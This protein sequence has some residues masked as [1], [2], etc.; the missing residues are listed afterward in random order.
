M[1]TKNNNFG[2]LGYGYV[3]RATHVGLLNNQPINVHDI[4]LGTTLANLKDSEYVFVCIPT[5]TY[6]DIINLKNEVQHLVIQ[7]PNVKIIIRS[8]LPIGTC[9]AI[10]KELGIDLIYIPEFLRERFWEEDCLKRPLV[11]GHTNS[12]LPEW[13]KNEKIYKCS[14]K[15]AEI[16]KI[17]SNTFAIMRIAFANLFYDLSQEMEADYETV[18]K[19]Y[20][21]IKHDQT[22]LEI[23]G[24]DGTRGFNGKCLP[25]DLDFFIDT[26]DANNIDS[27]WLKNIREN[28]KKWQ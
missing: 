11:V 23:P 9:N 6:Q 26:L 25:K 19:I 3:G 18:N 10:E 16:V 17:F 14:H 15:E 20:S 13:I 21:M 22:Y 1:S 27:S 12:Q 28:N 24:P 4:I 2:I 7:N 8:T 5:S